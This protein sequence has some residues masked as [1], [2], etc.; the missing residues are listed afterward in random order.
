MQHS[1]VFDPLFEGIEGG[2]R[3]NLEKLVHPGFFSAPKGAVILRQGSKYTMLHGL[4]A[5]ESYAEMLDAGGKVLRIET[6]RSPYFFAPAVLFASDNRMPGTV[7][8]ASAC[9]IATI[10]GKEL[11]SLCSASSTV[12]GNLLRIVSDR[13][14]FLSRR[15]SFISFTTIREKVLYYLSTLSEA[16]G[17]GETVRLDMPIEQLA[18]YFGVTRPALSRVFSK[19]EDDGVIVRRGR[20]VR[21]SRP[22]QW[23]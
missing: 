13:F 11:L 15:I 10:S 3:E 17:E 6:F 5:G 14:M 21:L 2:E 23:R 8:A 22:E 4:A 7:Y 1:G 19:L 16:S 20:D 12:L 18:E 9:E